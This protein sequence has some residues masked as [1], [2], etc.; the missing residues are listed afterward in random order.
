VLV[1]ARLRLGEVKPELGQLTFQ[2]PDLLPKYGNLAVLKGEIGRDR[3]RQSGP[4]LGRQRPVLV[5]RGILAS[6]RLS[7]YPLK[8][9]T[10]RIPYSQIKIL[11]EP[12][13]PR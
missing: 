1:G 11:Q 10:V 8:P 12:N 4:N 3:R 2:G 6:A 5:H 13:A 9:L 7:A